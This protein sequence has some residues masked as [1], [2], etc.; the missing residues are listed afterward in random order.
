MFNPINCSG[1]SGSGKTYHTLQ[2]LGQLFDIAGGGRETD[3]FKHLQASLTV[4][5]SL[6]SAA[7][8]TNQDSS[9]LV[10][11]IHYTDAGTAV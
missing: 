1:E 3:A 7:T 6:G 9:R 8:L 4:L 11:T 5:R 2:M 10:S